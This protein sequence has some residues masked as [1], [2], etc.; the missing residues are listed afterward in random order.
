MDKLFSTETYQNA[1]SEDKAD[2]VEKVYDYARDKAKLDFL[3]EHGVSYTNAQSDGVDV[4]K[5]NPIKGAIENDMMPDEYS[6]SRE[7]PGK[8]KFFKAN[9]ITYSDYESADEDGKRA[10]TWAY[11]NP[12]KYLV[13]KAVTDD[14]IEYRQYTSAINDIRADK[15]SS[16]KTISGSA[17]EKKIKYINSLN[18]DYG[19]KLILLKSEYPADDTY[20]REILDYLNSRSDISYEDE[21][22]IL[23]ELGFTVTADGRVYWD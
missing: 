14:L 23:K 6:F 10:Y 20:N 1:S 16:G 5:E 3:R 7:N 17:K 2:L 9:N 19:K 13:S 12:D 11:E 18:I 22:T 15:T 4:Y 21:I 8:Y